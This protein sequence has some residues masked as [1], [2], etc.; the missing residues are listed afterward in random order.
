MLSVFLLFFISPWMSFIKLHLVSA[1]FA[2]HDKTVK[3]SVI[4]AVKQLER[5]PFHDK[6]FPWNI[7]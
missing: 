6:Y 5:N 1:T 3:W 4:K 7:N 2:H